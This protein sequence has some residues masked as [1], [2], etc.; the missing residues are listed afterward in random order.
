MGC[1]ARKVKRLHGAN[2]EFQN[3]HRDAVHSVG[4]TVKNVK[5]RGHGVRWVLVA[6]RGPLCSVCGFL[7][8]FL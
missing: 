3:S 8:T 4:N 7:A 1:Q 6:A 5:I 2:W